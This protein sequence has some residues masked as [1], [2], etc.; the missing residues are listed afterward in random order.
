VSAGY[1]LFRTPAALLS[2]M[3]LFAGAGTPE[4]GR[5]FEFVQ[6]TPHRRPTTNLVCISSAA[7]PRE[8]ESAPVA[9]RSAS[10]AAS[11]QDFA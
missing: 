6:M 7:A 4:G 5:R 3:E 8:F 11:A 9:Y 10:E 2:A 1:G